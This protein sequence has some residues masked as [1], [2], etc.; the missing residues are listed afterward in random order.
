MFGSPASNT[1]TRRRCIDFRLSYLFIVFLLFLFLLLL[2]IFRF[3]I[4]K[5]SIIGIRSNGN[6]MS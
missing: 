4:Y 2:L 3:N 6:Q 1:S 5:E